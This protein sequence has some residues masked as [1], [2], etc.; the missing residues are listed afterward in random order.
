MTRNN[1]T[2][3]GTEETKQVNNYKATSD[4][5]TDSMLGLRHEY[6]HTFVP[7]TDAPFL[8]LLS[9]MHCTVTQPPLRGLREKAKVIQALC[10]V[11]KNPQP[12]HEAHSTY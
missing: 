4:V 1:T 12:Q 10:A 3:Y 6:K 11:I 7:S 2:V 8:Y 5:C 9:T